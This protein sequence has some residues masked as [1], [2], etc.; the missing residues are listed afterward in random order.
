MGDHWPW[1]A[2]ELDP[3]EPFK[4]TAFPKCRK[5]VCLLKTSVIGNYCVSCPEGQFSTLVGDL[6]CLG[7]TF[8]SDTAQET[9]WW[10][11]PNHTEPHPPPLTSF[12]RLQKAWNNLTAKVDWQAPKGLY[13]IC[14]KQ[15]YMVLPNSWF[16]VL[17]ARL[18]QTILF[19]TSP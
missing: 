7:Q 1:N 6:T 12:P 2:R 16:G 11:T 4:G 14:G 18:N 5:G 10:G 9:Q 17:H 13:W 8:Y 19:L 3:Q 15:V